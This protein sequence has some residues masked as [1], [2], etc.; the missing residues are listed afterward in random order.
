MRVSIQSEDTVFDNFFKIT[1]A[2]LQHELYTGQMSPVIT[3]LNFERGDSVAALVHDPATDLLY[4]VEQFRYPVYT[5]TKTEPKGGWLLELPG[6]MVELD[7][8]PENTMKR[9][10][11]E[12]IGY[13]VQTI[14]EIGHFFPNPGG[15]SERIYLFYAK[16]SPRQKTSLG[17]G[18]KGEGE[19][20]RT[21]E[22]SRTEAF[23]KL[24]AGEIIDAK[25][26][27]ALQWL[28]LAGQTQ[29]P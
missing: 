15:S 12:E 29:T 10:L 1:Q 24:A 4:L 11:Q 6:G 20:I 14:Q 19:N 18:L 26:L 13:S 21:V 2:R 7:G 8:H 27:I 5:K 23:R 9:E 16:V 25:T 22:I 28:Q 3:R 17:G